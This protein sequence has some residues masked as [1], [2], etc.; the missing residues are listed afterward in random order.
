MLRNI[1]SMH[2]V[3]LGNERMISI[4]VGLEDFLKFRDLFFESLFDPHF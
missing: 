3:L 2:S 1:L 4:L